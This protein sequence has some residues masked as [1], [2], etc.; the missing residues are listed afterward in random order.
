MSNDTEKGI[1]LNLLK[2]GLGVF[3]KRCREGVA[4]L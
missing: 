3:T 2:V 1:L 4:F